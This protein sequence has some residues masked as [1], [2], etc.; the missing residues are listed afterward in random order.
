MRP[1]LLSFKLKSE[2]VN[3]RFAKFNKKKNIVMEH[4]GILSYHV[5]IPRNDVNQNEE[6]SDNNG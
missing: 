4:D 1:K 2:I 6:E 3:N 5:K